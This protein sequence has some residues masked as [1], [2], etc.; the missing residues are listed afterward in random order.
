[1]VSGHRRSLVS[2]SDRDMICSGY[3][4]SPQKT[5]ASCTEIDKFNT[6]LADFDYGLRFLASVQALQKVRDRTTQRSL[7]RAY[8]RDQP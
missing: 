2:H 1:M 5:P 8:C 7:L 6:T 4:C 3:I